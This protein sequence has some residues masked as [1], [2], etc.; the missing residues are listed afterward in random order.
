M[1]QDTRHD[2]IVQ[3]KIDALSQDKGNHQPRATIMSS[4]KRSPTMTENNI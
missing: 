1:T 3:E 4:L 2:L